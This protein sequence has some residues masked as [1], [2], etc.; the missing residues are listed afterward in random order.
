MQWSGKCIVI[1]IVFFNVIVATV[2]VIDI[3]TYYY[4]AQ[5]YTYVPTHFPSD[6]FLKPFLQFSK[7]K[8]KKTILIF[9]N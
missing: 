2:I 8:T 3:Y 7:T 4:I 5:R 6:V 1:V 9:T